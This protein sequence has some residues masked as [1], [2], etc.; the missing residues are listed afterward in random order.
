MRRLTPQTGLQRSQQRIAVIGSGYVGLT[1]AA[2][3]SHLGHEVH[4]TDVLPDRVKELN[5]GKTP[6]VEL[7]LGELLRSG[8]ESGRL[9]FGGDNLAAARDADIVFLCLPTPQGPSGRA[10]LSYVRSA[11]SEIGPHLRPQA[12][13]VNK[14]TVPVGSMRQVAELIGRDD[15]HVVSNPEFMREGSAVRDFLTP[16]RV[17]IGADDEVAA[18]RVAALYSRLGA[19][20]VV[21]DPE[22][23]ELVKY[24]S[25]SFLAAKLSFVNSIA[26]LCETL[27][28]DI[29]HV[30]MGMGLDSRIGGQFLQPG[31][32]W[33]GSC[34][35]KDSAALLRIA[36]DAGFDFTL[37]Q[38]AVDA[39]EAQQE[40]VVDR[41]EELV[42]GQLDGLVIAMWGMTFKANTDDTRCSPALDIAG[43]LAA[44][45]ARVHAYDPTVA[46]EGTRS[47]VRVCANPL[48]ACD[49]AA[50]LLVATEWEEFSAVDL[51]EVAHRLTDRVVLDTRDIL[52]EGLAR[53]AGLRYEGVGISAVSVNGDARMAGVA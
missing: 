14:S 30:T 47:G 5:E 35:P 32:G 42:G 1:A 3:L 51:G 26:S 27:G 17:V 12:V 7:G 50:L 22:S 43:R 44:R 39:N 45:G 18:L 40:R 52:D 10:D 15:I 8:L 53:S 20:V 36:E 13:V 9:S 16:D 33:G 49:G 2:C 24:A 4:C 34:F 29:R 48:A 19:R 41:V 6:I 46:T 21:M 25:N 31:P 38:A 28:A 23:A 11:A 37:L